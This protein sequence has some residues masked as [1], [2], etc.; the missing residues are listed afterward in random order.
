MACG[1]CGGG[2]GT[3]CNYAVVDMACGE[4]ACASF[5]MNASELCFFDGLLEEHIEIIGTPIEYYSQDI[6][7]ATRDPLYDEPI[8]RKWRGPWRFK[9]F[10]EHAPAQ[11]E[12][13]EEG[14]RVSW[15]GTLFIPRISLERVGAPSPLEGD[16]VK[17]WENKFFTRHAT[18]GKGDPGGGYYFDV[19]SV[20]DDQHLFDTS[21][22]LGFKLGIARR[23][24][25]APERRLAETL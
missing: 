3:G 24:E 7:G 15:S 4:N 23:T 21:A 22:F 18:G 13:R 6:A 5:E 17:Y 8:A 2:C 12:V 11:P 20:D 9:A 19:T 10:V 14:F 16:V 1:G 25:F